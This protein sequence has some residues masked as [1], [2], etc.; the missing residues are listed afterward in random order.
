M[1][2]FHGKIMVNIREYY[3]DQDTG[4]LKPGRKGELFENEY[5]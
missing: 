2:A 4:E 3:N 5:E 1:G